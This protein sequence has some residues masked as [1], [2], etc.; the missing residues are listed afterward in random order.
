MAEKISYE[1]LAQKVEALEFEIAQLRQNEISLKESSRR[2]RKLLDFVPYPMAVFSLKGRVSYLNPAFTDVFGWT[3]EEMEGEKMPFVPTHLQEETSEKIKELFDQRIVPRYETKRLTKDGRLI[4]VVTRGEVFSKSEMGLSGELLILR[5][6]ANEKRF[7]KNNEAMLKISMALPEYTDLE[8][9]LDYI[10]SEIKR[11]LD[12]KGALVILL[13]EEKQE[14]FFQGAAYDDTATL[15]RIK[16]I[17]FSIHDLASGNVI[18]TGEPL[19]VNDTSRDLHIYPSRDMKFGHD[20]KNYVIVPI[21]SND[22]RIGVL[23]AYN[24]TVGI[25]EHTDVELLETIAG[26]VALSIENARFSEELKKAY[27]ELSSLDR[28]KDKAINHLS[29]ELKTPISIFSGTLSILKKKLAALPE[30][31]WEPT[32]ARAQRNMDRIRKL[33]SEVDDIIQEKKFETYNFLSFIVD[34]CTDLLETVIE[35]EIGNTTLIERVRH[36][37]KDIF[38]TR[39][40]EPEYIYLDAYTQERVNHLKPLFPHRRLELNCIVDSV[41]AVHMPKDLLQKVIDGL[42]R[43]A[44]ENT[45]DHGKV[46]VIVQKQGED[47]VLVVKDFGVG[48]TQEHRKKIFEGFFSTQETAS[49]SSKAPFDFNAGGRGADLLRMKIFSKRYDFSIHVSSLRC[50]FIPKVSDVCPGN[51]LECDFCTE[52]KDCFHSGGS[53]FSLVFKTVSN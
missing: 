11:L 20:F 47:V 13:D 41:P 1:E 27:R 48:I 34:Q 18:K 33:Q 12:T 14:F 19:I 46:D 31:T 30:N 42:V 52:K 51:I 10:S 21:K 8:D 2:Y 37:I 53:E 43:N 29:H 9:L 35:D 36:R 22:R 3:L 16:E 4:D 38:D 25:F 39:E 26:T 49:Y 28:A 40:T 7:A 15:K 17:R 6:I 44:V 24:K 45:P 5:D 50:R 32:M 23:A